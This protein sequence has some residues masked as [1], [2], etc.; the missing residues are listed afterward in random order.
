MEN[1]LNNLIINYIIVYLC[2]RIEFFIFYLEE[3]SF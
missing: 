3:S 1:L 2:L